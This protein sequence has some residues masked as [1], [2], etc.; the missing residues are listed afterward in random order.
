MPP[1]VPL[2]LAPEQQGT[3]RGF[4]D[5]KE[6]LRYSTCSQTLQLQRELTQAAV[7][8]LHLPVSP[9]PSDYSSTDSNSIQGLR[10]KVFLVC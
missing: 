8:L 2:P 6:A 1:I 4:Y 7:Q 3:A 10:S 9:P 5:S